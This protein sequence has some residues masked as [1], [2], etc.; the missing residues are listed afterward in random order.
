MRITIL[1]YRQSFFKN[2]DSRYIAILN[3]CGFKPLTRYPAHVLNE[4]GPMPDMCPMQ[5]AQELS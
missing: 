1:A 4:L 5:P 2:A 3:I